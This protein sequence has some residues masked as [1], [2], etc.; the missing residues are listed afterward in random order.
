MKFGRNQ[1]RCNQSFGLLASKPFPCVY[2]ATRPLQGPLSPNLT[3]PSSIKSGRGK[4]TMSSMFLPTF[5][6]SV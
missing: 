3:V 2:P 6:G 4:T 5:R 1:P